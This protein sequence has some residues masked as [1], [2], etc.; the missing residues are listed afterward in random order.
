MYSEDRQTIDREAMRAAPP[1]N[2]KQ[3][4]NVQKEARRLFPYIR[5][6][7]AMKARGVFVACID[8]REGV[9]TT[10]TPQ[11]RIKAENRPKN[12]RKLVP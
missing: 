12:E 3:A 10:N 6:R 5:R 9:Q 11:R 2:V 7:A 8:R 1:H 4:H